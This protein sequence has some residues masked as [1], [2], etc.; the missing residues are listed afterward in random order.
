MQKIGIEA[1]PFYKT[2]EFADGLEEEASARLE[3]Q[4]EKTG[5]LDA[6][7]VAEHDYEVLIQKCP[8]FLD[9][10]LYAKRAGTSD[11]AKL[12]VNRNISKSLQESVERILSNIHEIKNTESGIYLGTDG[13]FRQ[14]ILSGKQIKQDLPSL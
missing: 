12:V 13:C 7:V 1:V 5:M 4:L 9:T 3:A 14:G 8:E 11:F 2:V 10:V 6:L